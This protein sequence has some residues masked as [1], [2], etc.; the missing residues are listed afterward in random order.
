MRAS[1]Y[2]LCWAL[3]WTTILGGALASAA[4][5]PAV[6]AVVGATLLDGTGGAPLANTVILIENGHFIR[7]GRA[8]EVVVPR[9]AHVLS[10]QGKYVI[11]GLMDANVHLFYEIDA[12]NI[13][14]NQ[15]HYDD[16]IVEAAQV[17]LRNGVTTVFDTWGPREALVKAR[18][19]INSGQDVG[20]RI[21]L[22]GNI[23][24]F[25]GPFSDDFS[26]PV[27]VSAAF[28]KEINETWEQGVGGDL[29]WRTP[30]A[31]RLALR[32]YIARGQVDLIKYA[33]SGHTQEQFIAFSPEAQRAIVEEAHKAGLTVQAHS[34][35]V[36]SLRLEIE[37]GVDL[38]QHCSYSGIEP[39]PQ[40]T[41]NLI[42]AKQIPCAA[43]FE[44][45]KHRAWSKTHNFRQN[46]SREMEV[47]EI[48]HR[49]L[50]AAK[51][52]LL[53]TTDCGLRSPD[54]EDT[55]ILVKDVPEVP[56]RLQ[57]AQFLWLQAA[58][59]LGMAPMDALL[60]GTRNIASAYHKLDEIG[61]IETGKRA[62]LVVLDAD[63]LQDPRNY[64]A[65]RMV[66]KDGAVVDR[67]RLPTR[68]F[69]T[70]ATPANNP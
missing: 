69:L 22:G 11:P 57:E 32:D 61:T 51:A 64:R 23:V 14:R 60:A 40:A 25:N 67:D 47:S 52:P 46:Y 38:M 37:A 59:E 50:I 66:L 13:I 16:L 19:R 8:G 29:L 35:S 28:A 1:G 63:P 24:G 68:H 3:G 39:I 34:T 55:S 12:E 49:A 36:E 17:A 65:I 15:G 2:L 41:L 30:E 7:V 31:V 43:M 20:T 45:Q 27:G 53:L 54:E 70:R 21:F 4:P 10:A 48:N 6:T 42:V 26:P 62:D 44:T 18:A 5:K 9:G 58:H 56:V 33:A